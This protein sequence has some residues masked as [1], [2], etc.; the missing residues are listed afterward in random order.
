MEAQGEF[1]G[2]ASQAVRVG[3]LVF[4]LVVGAA[5]ATD[6]AIGHAAPTDS[7]ASN[8]ESWADVPAPPGGENTAAS[9][10]P[11]RHSRV[12][13]PVRRSRERHCPVRLC[14]VRHRQGWVRHSLIP[15]TSP[16]TC[17]TP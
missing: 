5:V 11:G 10:L 16:M 9:L 12:R 14:R 8:G 17:S 4:V 6:Q 1:M 7:D 15:A 13:C 3:A 2:Y